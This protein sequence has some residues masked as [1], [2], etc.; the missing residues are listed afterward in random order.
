LIGDIWK[1]SEDLDEGQ[2]AV[3]ASYPGVPGP[4]EPRSS[5]VEIRLKFMKHI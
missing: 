1:F 4:E 5:G 2:P 3:T